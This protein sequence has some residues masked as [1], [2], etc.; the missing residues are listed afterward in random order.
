MVVSAGFLTELKI[1]KHPE[2]LT[3]VGGT[4]HLLFLTSQ[5]E[6]RGQYRAIFLY[7]VTAGLTQRPPTAERLAGLLEICGY[8]FYG[9]ESNLARDYTI[10]RV[11]L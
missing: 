4:T 10:F 11:S 1:K 7:T 6:L 5:I 2:V 3:L 9:F 8:G